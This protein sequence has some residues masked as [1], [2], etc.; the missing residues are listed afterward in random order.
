MSE[1][2][3]AAIIS[4]VIQGAGAVGSATDKV[5]A[6][7]TSVERAGKRAEGASVSADAAAKKAEQATRELASQAT[8]ALSRLATAARF[9]K[10]AANVFGFDESSGVGAA[11]QGLGAAASGAASGVA[12]GK[13]L[14]P[15]GM[16][17]GGLI[18]AGLGGANAWTEYEKRTAEAAKR[19][20]QEAEKEKQ[21]NLEEELLRNAGLAKFGAL[22]RGP[23]EVQ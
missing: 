21:A 13:I 5:E 11:F 23:R 20:V 22:T 1:A 19:G 7:L 18:G 17:A 10:E 8:Q 14:G 4:L 16:L 6:D 9:A 15:W 12:A 2:V 3:E